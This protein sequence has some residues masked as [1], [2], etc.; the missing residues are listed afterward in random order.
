LVRW[1]KQGIEGA[2]VWR[3][4]TGRQVIEI[5]KANGVCDGLSNNGKGKE[6][7]VVVGSKIS[8]LFELRLEMNQAHKVAMQL[9]KQNLFVGPMM[10]LG[11]F[12]VRQ[13]L[14]RLHGKLSQSMHVG[15]KFEV[16]ILQ[17]LQV[18]S[19]GSSSSLGNVK[20]HDNASVGKGGQKSLPPRIVN[21]QIRFLLSHQSVLHDESSETDS[22]DEKERTV[23]PFAGRKRTSSSEKRRDMKK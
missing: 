17:A 14:V 19:Y 18:L 11:M 7:R 8:P 23:Q 13:Q 15:N 4:E 3:E 9:E 20:E 6:R 1:W 22:Q 12:L 2:E 10:C 5:E 21:P 16:D